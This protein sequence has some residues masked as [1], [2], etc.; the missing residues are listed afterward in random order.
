M[1]YKI[2]KYSYSEHI[3]KAEEIDL[4]LVLMLMNLEYSKLLFYIKHTRTISFVK[5]WKLFMNHDLF[6]QMFV[7]SFQTKMSAYIGPYEV[8]WFLS[9][10]LFNF[11]LFF[12][13]F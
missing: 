6:V 9:K 5:I 2:M 10:I 7:L 4:N 11:F 3:H 13:H 8:C 1:S 12:S